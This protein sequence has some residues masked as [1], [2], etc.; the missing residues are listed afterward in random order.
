MAG[1]RERVGRWIAG[2][3]S[4][5]GRFVEYEAASGTSSWGGLQIPADP[6]SDYGKLF[7]VHVWTYVCIRT[8]T[9]ATA[10]IP[11]MVQT[12]RKDAWNDDPNSPLQQL[13]D[14]VNPE[15]TSFGFQEVTMACL[16]TFGNALWLKVR[17]RGGRPAELWPMRPDMVKAKP[18]TDRLIGAYEYG[19]EG[20][21][22]TFPAEDV[23]HLRYWDP[24]SSFFGTSP[25][26]PLAESI[27][28]NL[29]GRAFTK[30]F[31][32][33]SA[34]PEGVLSTQDEDIPQAELRKLRRMWEDQTKGIDNAHRTVIMP[35]GVEWKALTI[36]PPLAGMG[37]I[38]TWSL[39][40]ILAGFG[41]NPII[42][43]WLENATLANVREQR[44]DWYEN[45]LLPELG[46]IDASLV[47]Q[48]APELGLDKAS[49][50]IRRVT[51]GIAVLRENEQ[52]LSRRMLAEMAAGARSPNE[53]REALH[54]GP[55]IPGGDIYY[56]PAHMVPIT[57]IGAAG[58]GPA[59]QWTKALHT[60]AGRALQAKSA[61]A[62][63]RQ[64]QVAEHR[65]VMA[66]WPVVQDELKALLA[67]VDPYALEPFDVDKW[68]RRFGATDGRLMTPLG[69][70]MTDAG[71]AY[72]TGVI[73]AEPWKALARGPMETRAGQAPPL[74]R[75][76]KAPP[77]PAP[78]EAW[79][80]WLKPDLQELPAPTSV[81]EIVEP[82]VGTPDPATAIDIAARPNMLKLSRQ[83]ASV[84]DDLFDVVKRELA[85][86]HAE[87]ENA[88]QLARRLEEAILGSAERTG[89]RA[90]R[91]ARTEM[92]GACQS[93]EMTAIRL[94]KD[95]G[96]A[97][98][99]IWQC[100]FLPESRESHMAADGQRRDVEEP[101]TVGGESLDHPGDPAGSANN[102]VHCVCYMHTELVE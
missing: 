73:H 33:N 95:E 44:R 52:G 60:G 38:A 101:F 83:L 18:G 79:P 82:L 71:L 69:E 10:T 29:Y 65:L 64:A 46:L 81:V 90:K 98:G 88:E 67:D 19:P 35:R 26:T 39:Q 20:S 22:T 13:L 78:P 94:A 11:I 50:R 99:K 56:V 48:L 102:V 3:K 54:V 17:D 66:Y 49:V 34:V 91:V 74:Q 21:A 28:V 37:E 70:A 47:E 42:V 51:D 41:L 80:D 55:P 1:L 58:P 36:A 23:L 92:H 84:P 63:R 53:Y 59:K 77:S 57:E 5:P 62:F 40:E 31:F 45:K 14:S 96:V 87:A 72:Y 68:A 100:S 8:L 32:Q 27:A 24:V 9:M 85:L 89:W 76:T 61:A 15:M 97:T 6:Y 93:G 30:K 86:G 4:M 43:G 16:K 75:L 12:K 7:R 25:I 2:Q